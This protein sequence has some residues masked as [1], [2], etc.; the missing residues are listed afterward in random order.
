MFCGEAMTTGNITR[1]ILHRQIRVSK[2]MPEHHKRS[3]CQ[4]TDNSVMLRNSPGVLDSII[5]SPT[6][7]SVYIFCYYYFL[8]TKVW[9]SLWFMSRIS[10]CQ[11]SKGSI[12]WLTPS[13]RDW[14]WRL[15][16]RSVTASVWRERAAKRGRLR[17]WLFIILSSYIVPVCLYR[18]ILAVWIVWNGMKRESK[19]LFFFFNLLA[20]ILP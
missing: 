16:F 18:A 1:D 4:W 9:W 2:Q 20:T 3:I 5:L 8:C 10:K 6:K 11:A 7:N 13:S 14:D 19:F 15:S 12:M 17:C